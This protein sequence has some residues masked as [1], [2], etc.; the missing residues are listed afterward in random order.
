MAFMG[1]APSTAQTTPFTTGPFA[2]EQAYYSERGE[3]TL[4][5][6]RSDS[7][8]LVRAVE[9]QVDDQVEG[10]CWKN[11]GAVTARLRV[12]LERSGV[13]VFEEPLAFRG[14]T[15]PIL[16]FVALGGRVDDLGCAASLQMEMFFIGREEMGS[17]G[18]TKNVFAITSLSSMWDQSS[19]MW[20]PSP[21]DERVL[22]TAQ[23]WI[24]TLAADI[25]KSRRVEAV[26]RF[27]EVWNEGL[28]MTAAAWEEQWG[29]YKPE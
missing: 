22:S 23:Q 12:E 19:V 25:S 11:A 2:T 28:P 3:A 20:G 26:V 29:S 9:L 4:R 5:L 14:P 8:G 16:R 15:S 13:A 21:L 6:S 10:G 24:D 1:A 27:N 17:L 7:L 18:Y